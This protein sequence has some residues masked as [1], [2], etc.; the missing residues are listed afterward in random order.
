MG[1]DTARGCDGLPSV[2]AF[3]RPPNSARLVGGVAVM[4]TAASGALPGQGT[5]ITGAAAVEGLRIH[6]M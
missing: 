5:D 4:H 6:G 2:L 1:Y 3:R